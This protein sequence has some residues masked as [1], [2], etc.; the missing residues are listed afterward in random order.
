MRIL[1]L[2]LALLAGCSVFGRHERDEPPR[3]ITAEERLHL[4]SENRLPGETKNGVGEVIR[5]LAGFI[6]GVAVH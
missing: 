4:E 1:V 3:G 5:G 6:P 2:S